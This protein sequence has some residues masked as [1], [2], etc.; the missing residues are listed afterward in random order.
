MVLEEEYLR[1]SY[2][3]D[4]EYIEGSLVE[5]RTGDFA[6]GRTIAKLAAYCGRRE[7]EWGG[8]S[9]V[10]VRVRTGDQRI[11]V[12]DFCFAQETVV[13]DGVVRDEVLC[14]A[15][16]VAAEGLGEGERAEE[17]LARVAD[18]LAMGAKVVW[19]ID[20]KKRR[21]WIHTAEGVAEA[22]GGVVRGPGFEVPIAAL[23]DS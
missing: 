4:C 19:V 18:F 17:V 8:L 5:R 15:P 9:L 22:K 16:L 10:V 1:T 14:S 21:A 23:F 7:R 2:S 11:R 6:H 20:P 3:P 13:R 12:A